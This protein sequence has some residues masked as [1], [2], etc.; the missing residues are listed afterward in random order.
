MFPKFYYNSVKQEILTKFP[1][2]LV[3]VIRA[4][5]AL[6]RLD[7]VSVEVVVV[8]VAS[9]PESRSI[10]MKQKLIIAPLG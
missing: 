2:A 5:R 9:I 8:V 4:G 1:L 10:Q 7:D 3:L 6:P